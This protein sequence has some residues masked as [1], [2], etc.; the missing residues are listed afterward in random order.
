MHG[1]GEVVGGAGEVLHDAAVA[2]LAETDQLVVLG[3]D[4][5]SASRE[6]Q[7]EGRLVG[8]EVVDV[9]DEFWEC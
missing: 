7:R 5:T 1:G 3:D 9:E 2:G 6:V 4:L 8:A